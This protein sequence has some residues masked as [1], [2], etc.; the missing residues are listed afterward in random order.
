VRI[1]EYPIG[2]IETD[3]S[4]QT[5][6]SHRKAFIAILDNCM[7]TDRIMFNQESDETTALAAISI[8]I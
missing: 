7:H 4:A 5:R 3:N 6:F 2:K 1:S 8:L